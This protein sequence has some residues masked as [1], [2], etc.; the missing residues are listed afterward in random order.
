LYKFYV[1]R[2]HHFFRVVNKW[3]KCRQN[4]AEMSS[5]QRQKCRQNAAEMSSKRLCIPWGC[6]GTELL[7]R[8]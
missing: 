4:A 1:F 7:K 6:K 5:K 2:L 8:F 3:Q